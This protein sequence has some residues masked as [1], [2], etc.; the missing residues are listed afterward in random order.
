MNPA[1]TLV[2]P[3]VV[4]CLVAGCGRS[5]DSAPTPR[6]AFDLAAARKTIDENNARFTKAHVTGDIAAVDAL[7]TKDARSLPPG[8]GPVIGLAA[9]HALTEEYV[10]LGIAEFTETTTTFDGNEDLIVDQ[11]DYTV[12]YGKDRTVEKG[13]YLNVWKKEQGVWKIATNIWNANAAAGS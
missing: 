4:A 5:S 10:K 3:L 7:F 9:I 1:R 8:A 13:K 12:V 2:L 11:G 6:A